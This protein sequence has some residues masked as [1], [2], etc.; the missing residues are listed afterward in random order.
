MSDIW[1]RTTDSTFKNDKNRDVTPFKTWKDPEGFEHFLFSK[2]MFFNPKYVIPEDPYELFQKFLEGG[3]RE[4]PSDG[5]L[6]ADLAEFEANRA[7]TLIEQI[8]RNPSHK[9]YESACHE[10]LKNDRLSLL[11]GTIKLYCGRYTT[12]DWRR[13]RFTDD[14]DFWVFDKC[15][16]EHVLK[17]L[18]FKKN[19]KTLEYEKMIN[20]TNLDTGERESTILIASNDVDQLMDFGGG[21]YLEGSTIK[22]IFKKKLKRGHDVDLNDIINVMAEN[23]GKTNDLKD[24]AWLAIEESANVRSS[25]VTANMLSLCRFS[26][27]IADHFENVYNAIDT[28]YR[29]VLDNQKYPD[30]LLLKIYRKSSHHLDYW[31]T[32]N[33]RNTRSR[34]FNNLFKEKRMKLRHSQ[35]LRIF[36]DKVLKLLNLKYRHLKIIFE[37]DQ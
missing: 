5:N 17:E 29:E 32:L 19:R 15:L 9:F 30:K 24:K 10:L 8:S 20:W 27:G 35:N 12:K 2:Q 34:I 37:V 6:P 21:C 28:Y 22:D 36:S 3:S 1:D 11:R 4:Y 13:K 25:R 18:G 23:F 26:K 31:F 33:E 7:L 14:I 16:L